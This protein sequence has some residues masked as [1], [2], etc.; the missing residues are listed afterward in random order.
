MIATLTIGPM[1]SGKSMALLQRQATLEHYGRD[2]IIV[3]TGIDT[4]DPGV[5]KSRKSGRTVPAYP[6]DK[7]KERQY[8]IVMVDESQFLT[9]EEIDIILGSGATHVHFYGLNG[10]YH[11]NIFPAIARLLPR[12]D[13]VHILH[14]ECDTCGEPA[15]HSK[16]LENGQGKTVIIGSD[17]YEAACREHFYS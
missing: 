12:V 5:I 17:Q 10:D 7:V 2:Y 16:L 9:D 11:G 6:I 15:L 3:K 1:F 14:A 4:R 13:D 8:H